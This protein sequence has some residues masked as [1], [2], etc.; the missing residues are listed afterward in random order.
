[1]QDIQLTKKG[2]SKITVI[3]L[4]DK[5]KKVFA[6]QECP[7]GFSCPSNEAHKILS[8]AVTH[9]LSVDSEVPVIIPEHPHLTREDLAKMFT[10]IPAPFHPRTLFAI[11]KAKF[12]GDNFTKELANLSVN[13]KFEKGV[14]YPVYDNEMIFVVGKDGKAYKMTPASWSKV[15]LY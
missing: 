9:D 8:W 4:T 10:N 15:T 2:K 14:E 7:D 3:P 11:G 5:A 1:M 6:L 13:D 12:K